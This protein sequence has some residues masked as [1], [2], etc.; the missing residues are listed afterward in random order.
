LVVPP[1]AL[2]YSSIELLDAQA[3]ALALDVDGQHHGFDFL[4]LLEVAHGVFAGSFQDRSDRCTRPSMP[5][6]RPTKTPKSVIDLIGPLTLSPRL[7]SAANSSHGLALALL[8]AQRDAALVFV[9]LQHH[10]F[11]FVAQLTRPWTG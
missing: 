6:A 5:P 11:D 2:E 7:C 1:E 3:D 8:H 10:D 9:D 4:A